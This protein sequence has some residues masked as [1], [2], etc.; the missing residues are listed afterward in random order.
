V[1]DVKIA[2]AKTFAGK[3]LGAMINDDI[4]VYLH[5]S[6]LC[7]Y[8]DSRFAAYGMGGRRRRRFGSAGKLDGVERQSASEKVPADTCK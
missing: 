1:G 6:D 5:C 4:T 8:R 3:I 2:T 7:F